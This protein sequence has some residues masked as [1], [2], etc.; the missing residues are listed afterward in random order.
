MHATDR[1][2]RSSGTFSLIR[3]HS[4]CLFELEEIYDFGLTNATLMPKQDQVCIKILN[5]IEFY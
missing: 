3:K 2:K 4:Q 5:D 1:R